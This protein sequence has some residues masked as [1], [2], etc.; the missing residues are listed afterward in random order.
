[1]E[2]LHEAA[3]CISIKLLANTIVTSRGTSKKQSFSIRKEKTIKCQISANNPVPYA[4][5]SALAPN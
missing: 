5:P 4:F 1:M 3:S 2:G